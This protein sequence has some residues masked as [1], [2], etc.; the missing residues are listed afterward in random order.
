[1]QNIHT[2]RR[3]NNP[4]SDSPFGR[5]GSK[6]QADCFRHTGT[7]TDELGHRIQRNIG[8]EVTLWG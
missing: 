3:G 8:Q 7:D 1:M 4:V 2:R 5:T 6:R